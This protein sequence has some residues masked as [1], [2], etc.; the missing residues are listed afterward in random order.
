MSEREHSH[1][2]SPI[3]KQAIL[4]VE[5]DVA[6]GQMIALTLSEETPYQPLIAYSG[7]EALRIVQEI[8]PVLFI[9]DYQLP[10]M[11]GLQLYDQLHKNEELRMVPAI[12]MSAN[13]PN[14]EL[15]K[16]HILGIKKPFE[17]DELFKAIA[18]L[19]P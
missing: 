2:S 16:R 13:L 14:A 6:I 3:Q 18:Y 7:H 17:L 1:P 11:T 19:L 12:M 5:D 8:K 4:I 10:S 9:L 15:E